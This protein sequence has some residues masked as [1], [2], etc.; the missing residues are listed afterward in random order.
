MP[1]FLPETMKGRRSWVDIKQMLTKHE[2]QP[3]PLFP[4]R[5]SITVDGK[6]NIFHDKNKFTQYLS[7]NPAFQ[8]LINEKL[9]HKEGNY[10]LEKVRK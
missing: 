5:H 1:D 4:A 10:T 3:K 2:C 7:T 9:Q 8:R 6:I